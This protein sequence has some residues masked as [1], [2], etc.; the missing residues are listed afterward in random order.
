MITTSFAFTWS[1]VLRTALKLIIILKRL[2]AKKL[3]EVLFGSYVPSP[4]LLPT[5]FVKLLT[6]L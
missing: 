2:V 1:F 5:L 4:P 3:A 6:T